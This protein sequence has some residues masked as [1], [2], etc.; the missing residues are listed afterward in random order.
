MRAFI[1]SLDN[2]PGTLADLGEA[3]GERGINITG[4][5]GSTWEGN[6]SAAI[7][8]ND[9][10]GATAA[11]DE[12][13]LDYRESELVSA[14]LEDRPG[15]LGEAARRLANGGVN[16]ELIMPTGMQGSRLSVAFGVDDP[17]RAR[18]ALGELATAGT[19]RAV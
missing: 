1:V 5:A 13:G 9:D 2:R 3:L 14:D 10:S 17:A 6:G 7:V 4:I 11:L 16:I 18:E 15:A 8:T 12:A 19:T